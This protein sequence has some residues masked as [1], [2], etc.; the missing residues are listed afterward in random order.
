MTTSN[1]NTNGKDKTTSPSP[2]ERP[3]KEE[4]KKEPLFLVSVI[5]A[6][7]LLVT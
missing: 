6:A 4:C 1:N 2:S 3:D 7:V 5:S